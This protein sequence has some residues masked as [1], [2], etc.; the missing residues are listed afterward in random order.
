M[1]TFTTWLQ[2]VTTGSLRLIYRSEAP[3][4]GGEGYQEPARP[5]QTSR[6]AGSI[7]LGGEGPCRKKQQPDPGSGLEHPTD[8][9]A[10]RLQS[11]R[12][13]QNWKD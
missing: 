11:K 7:L 9:G 5:R 12:A 4:V 13:T 8:R 1:I 10:W 3:R 6:D 2:N